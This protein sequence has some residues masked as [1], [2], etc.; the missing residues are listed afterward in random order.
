MT[1]RKPAEDAP[2][3]TRE[4]RQTGLHLYET[5]TI[6][7]DAPGGMEALMAMLRAGSPAGRLAR[8]KERAKAYQDVDDVHREIREIEDV[9]DNKDFRLAI[10]FMLLAIERGLD[11]LDTGKYLATLR[12]GAKHKK[13]Q[14][15]KASLPRKRLDVD[16]AKAPASIA[17]IIESMKDRADE[18][19][20]PLPAPELWPEVF[21]ALDRAWLDPEE[22]CDDKGRPVEI[23]YEGGRIRYSS[24]KSMLSTAR[25]QVDPEQS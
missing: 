22:I 25:R 3:V 21:A 9:I 12:T 5:Q 8:V 18:L 11:L 1:K 14:R 16:A 23:R 19:G 20:D 4:T 7:P 2:A 10:P 24:F 17:A 15:Y 13:T 6:N